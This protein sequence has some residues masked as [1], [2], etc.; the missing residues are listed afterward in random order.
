[1]GW[2]KRRTSN[3]WAQ[4]DFLVW[5]LGCGV[6]PLTRKW[7]GHWKINEVVIILELRRSDVVLFGV[8]EER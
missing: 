1:M 4:F 7:A 8:V 6:K 3:N 5:W 2:R